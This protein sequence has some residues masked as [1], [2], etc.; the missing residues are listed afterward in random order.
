MT[1]GFADAAASPVTT[2]MR[3]AKLLVRRHV[4][5]ACL[6]VNFENGEERRAAA[7]VRQDSPVVWKRTAA[8][9]ADND[10]PLVGGLT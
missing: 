7:S 1:D 10:A 2:A 6:S 8:I 4:R 5:R 3:P 9:V